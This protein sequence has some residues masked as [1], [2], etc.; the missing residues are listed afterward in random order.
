MQQYL[1][2]L[3][4]ILDN[5]VDKGDRTGTGTRSVFG[6]QM[7]F[8]LQKGF[9]AVTTKKLFTKGAF[10]EMLWFLRGDTSLDFLHKHDVHIWDE[11]AS[12]DKNIGFM[13]GYQ[14]IYWGFQITKLV[15]SIKTNPDSRRHFVSAWNVWDLPDESMSPQDNVSNG[16]MAL[17]PCHPFFQCYVAN[18]KLSLHFYMRSS[19]ALIGLPFNIAGYALLTHLLAQ[20][21]DLDVGELIY[22]CGDAHIYN[23]HFE[24]VKLQLSRNPLPLP[25]LVIKRKPDDIFSYA[26]DDFELVGYE[27]YLHITAGQQKETS[28]QC[29]H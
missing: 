19:D 20:Q 12:C 16:K 11:W 22:S 27:R 5:G 24:Q 13:Y 28:N 26:L 9:P 2:L 10:V 8:D 18:G 25:N 14:W 4:H 7:R 3:Q 17:A 23:N 15:T 1:D 21:C 29:Y 6:Y